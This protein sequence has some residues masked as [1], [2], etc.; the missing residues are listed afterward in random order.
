VSDS[1]RR[2][3]S[4]R[5]GVTRIALGLALAGCA[6]G[7]RVVLEPGDDP[8]SAARLVGAR[9]RGAEVVYLGELHDNPHHH[10]AQ[11]RVLDV[12]VAGG[13]RPA[14]AFEML[15]QDQQ[16]VAAEVVA[17]QD[18]ATEAERRLRWQARGWPDFAMYWPLFEVARR[19]RLEVVAA[20]L[21]P[22]L[23]R[24]IGREG[25]AALGAPAEA[26][27]S[28]L[29]P[30]PA[31]ERA[32]GATI[33]KAHCDLLPEGRI[34]AMVEAWHAR[35]VTMARRLAAAL[36]RTGQV[37]VI[38]GR[39]HQDPGGLPAQLEALRPGT[40]QLVVTLLE[41][42]PAEAREGLLRQASGDIL[43]LTPA[44]ARRDPCEGLR[45]RLGDERRGRRG[46][47]TRDHA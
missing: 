28:L 44:T 30:D 39:G 1:R 34:P 36:G 22:A 4:W 42:G 10:A 35:N 20:D 14:V 29:L 24:R 7:G 17:G 43:W 33:A 6:A 8:A 25:L 19:A 47:P 5:P 9:A 13:G 27:R 37:V 11:A 16:A 12:I 15:S 21:D 46:Q 18:S 3:A 41:V 2:A 45:R 26:L 32:L 31:R 40:R 23:A 38:I